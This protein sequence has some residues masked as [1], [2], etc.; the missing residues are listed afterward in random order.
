MSNSSFGI[1]ETAYWQIC[2][3]C[4]CSEKL[5]GDVIN[6][7]CI[8]STL[9]GNID[10]LSRSICAAHDL[11]FVTFSS[12]NDLFDFLEKQKQD[13]LLILDEYQ[14]LKAAGR[15][16]E[17]DSILQ[18]VIDYLPKNLKLVLCGSYITAMRELL[19]EEN[20]L[21]GRF[22]A[23]IHLGE[24]DYYAA[25][26]FSTD[27][28]IR[29]QIENYAVFGGS[30]Y[31]CSVIYHSASIR[32]NIL[33]LLLPSTGILR[34]YIGSVLLNEIQK[35]YDVRIFQIIGNGRKRYGEI[36]DFIGGKN[37]GLLDKQ[38]KTLLE[39]EAVQKECPIIR[40]T[41]K[42]KQFYSIQD[43]L[44]RFYFTYIFA[45]MALITRLGESAFTILISNHH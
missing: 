19:E 20:P 29:K 27:L 1:W 8:Q 42:K 13:I 37:N 21:F 16:N 6:H 24:M 26:G 28:D 44:M 10:L 45:N 23:V 7:L 22:T 17:V 32:K 15:N 14:Y 31:A 18:G 35:A 11:P 38:R 39:M 30:P 12:L 5:H 34:I 33:D 9:S 4:A 40:Q 2:I 36:A 43:N 41:D 25:A 3:N